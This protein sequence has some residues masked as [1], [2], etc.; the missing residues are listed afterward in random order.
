MGFAGLLISAQVVTSYTDDVLLYP[1]LALMI[2]MSLLLTLAP[3]LTIPSL[4]KTR[5]RSVRL[6][7]RHGY[8]AI[9]MFLF[10]FVANEIVELLREYLDCPAVV[11]ATNI[12][13]VLF[14]L[15]LFLSFS[16]WEYRMLVFETVG[17]KLIKKQA[18]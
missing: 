14:A 18:K 7:L 17:S 6:L 4:P 3:F 10:A 2:T 12:V 13:I 9:A 15:I 1:V 5:V 11:T 16:I 8:P